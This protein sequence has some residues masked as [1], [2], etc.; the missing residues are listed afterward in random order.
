[1]KNRELLLEPGFVLKQTPKR[2][3]SINLF[4]PTFR[5]LL[6]HKAFLSD[7]L[8]KESAVFYSVQKPMFLMSCCLWNTC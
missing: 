4:Q 8:R 2:W 1:M 6:E 5:S 3:M 7:W